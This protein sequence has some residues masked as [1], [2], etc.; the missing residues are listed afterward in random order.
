MEIMQSISSEIDSIL[1]AEIELAQQDDPSL[2][3]RSAFDV[4]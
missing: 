2:I 4:I 1:R 3:V